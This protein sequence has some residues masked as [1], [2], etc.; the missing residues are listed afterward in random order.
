MPEFGFC[1][2]TVIQINRGF[3]SL[4]LST[5]RDISSFSAP[6][7]KIEVVNPL[8]LHAWASN[9]AQVGV[10]IA[11]YTSANFW[12]AEIDESGSTNIISN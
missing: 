11:E 10:S 5:A 12:Y 7:S 9:N 8:I 3:S 1:P 6:I 2:Y 4:I